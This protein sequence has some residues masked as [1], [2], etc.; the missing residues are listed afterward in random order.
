MT[1]RLLADEYRRARMS[2][3]P[4]LLGFLWEAARA[5]VHRT[6]SSAFSEV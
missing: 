6:T 1:P 4:V 5:S 2:V 3:P